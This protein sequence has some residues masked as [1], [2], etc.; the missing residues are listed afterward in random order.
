MT[1][2]RNSKSTVFFM[3]GMLN[4]N[5]LG[6]LCKSNLPEFWYFPNK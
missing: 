6:C 4:D 1:Q 5:G 3:G 2:N